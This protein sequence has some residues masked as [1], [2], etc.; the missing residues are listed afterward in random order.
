MPRFFPDAQTQADA[1]RAAWAAAGG[2]T[3]ALTLD[4]FEVLERRDD[5]EVLRVPEFVPS[6]SQLGC[7]VAGGYRH[8]P[9]TLI[10]TESMSRRRQQF[11]VL[12]ELGHHLQRT[13]VS[14]GKAVLRQQ[15]R[16]GF[17]DAACDAFA[18]NILLP[19]DMVDEAS[20]PFGGPS[21]QTAVDLFGTSNASRAAISVRM[22]GRLRGAGAVAV[23]NDVGIV[24]FAAARGSIYAP[25]RLSDQSENPLIRAALEDPDPNRVWS[26][27]DARIWYSSGHSTNELYGQAAWAGDRL[28]VVMVEESAPWRSY[29]PPKE[30]TALRRTSR[31]ATCD[32]CGK[33]FETHRHCL[34]CSK[35]KC[36]AGHCGCTAPTLFEKMCDSCTFVKHTSQFSDGSAVCKECE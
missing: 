2:S 10:V 28:F 14:L 9:P 34:T 18:A 6:N 3:E 23:V 26:R 31:W 20:I 15:D 19:D 25:A 35:P 33:N 11:T 24:T 17:E 5:L 4:A 1:M 21:A 29:S 13:T 27:D 32:I 12:H 36:P 16:S 22:A 8:S 30:N 7:S